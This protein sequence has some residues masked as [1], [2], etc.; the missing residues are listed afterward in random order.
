M[1]RGLVCSSLPPLQTYNSKSSQTRPVLC[2]ITSTLKA[3][4]ILPDAVQP[5]VSIHR[6][7]PRS[8]VPQLSHKKNYVHYVAD[9]IPPHTNL[10]GI[11]RYTPYSATCQTPLQLRRVL[12]NSFLVAAS[13]RFS[14]DPRLMLQS[15]CTLGHP[16]YFR[17]NSLIGTWSDSIKSSF[18]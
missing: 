16:I 14:S 10:S 1:F 4:E 8:I 13:N 11:Y 3:E 5:L 18:Q 7:L 17:V 12:I 9:K 2:H 15:D 6:T